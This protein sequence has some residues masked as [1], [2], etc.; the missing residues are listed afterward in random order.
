[1]DY[2]YKQI[3]ELPITILFECIKTEEPKLNYFGALKTPN[4]L[5][6]NLNVTRCSQMA[7]A[8]R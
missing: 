1:M 4:K 7:L 2:H 3:G 5:M 6:G 8:I